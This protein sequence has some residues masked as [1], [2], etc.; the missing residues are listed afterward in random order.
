MFF[1]HKIK[2]IGP[3]DRVL[4]IGPGA[5]P[6]SR[7][8]V[9]LELKYPNEEEELLQRGGVPYKNSFGE[10]PVTLYDGGLFP[11]KDGEFD[12][13]ICSH[14]IEHVLDP[15][16]FMEEVFRVG[17]G[18]GYIEYP[19]ITYEYL[20]G[21]AVHKHFLK[22]DVDRNVLIFI[23][24]AVTGFN[25]FTSIHD[26][27]YSSLDNGWDDLCAANKNQFFEG[28]EFNQPFRLEQTNNINLLCPTQLRIS[29]KNNI[30]TLIGRVLNRLHL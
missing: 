5:T 26:F 15:V 1:A 29:K 12:Y 21:F 22:Y 25:Q 2:S 24:K 10:R 17:K 3:Q 14:V 20:Y 16:G 8:N 28:F 27:F 6:H 7:S 13:V 30:R 19:L 18:R 11:F 4:E 9:F 23:P